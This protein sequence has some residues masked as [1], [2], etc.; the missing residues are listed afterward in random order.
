MRNIVGVLKTKDMDDYMKLGE[1][2]LKLNKMLAISGPILTGIAAIGSAFVG[3]TN[4]SLAVMVGVICGAM[5]SV[6][7]TFEHGGQVGMVFEMYRSNA[8]FF[9]LMQETI[10]SNVNE[11]D[12]ERRENGE[13]FQT[14]VALQLGRSLSELRHLAASAASSS[15]SGR[16]W[17]QVKTKIKKDYPSVQYTAWTFWPVVGWINH[18][19]VPLQFRVIFHSAVANVL[20]NISQFTSKDHGIAES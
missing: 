1:K 5:A 12:V 2:A 6:V 8:G 7:N 16:P 10:E 18:Q 3:T 19:Y 9:K 20:G 13:V 17:M 4:G 15:S 14:K 11:R